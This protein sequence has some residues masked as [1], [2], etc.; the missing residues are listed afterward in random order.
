MCSST[1]SLAL[2]QVL[3]IR[4]RDCCKSLDV[5]VHTFRLLSTV[6]VISRPLC[7]QNIDLTVRHLLLIRFGTFHSSWL[8]WAEIKCMVHVA[9]PKQPIYQFKPVRKSRQQVLIAYCPNLY[10]VPRCFGY[11][12]YG[13]LFNIY[14]HVIGKNNVIGVN[15]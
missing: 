4:N 9:L 7:T 6:S 3:G 8:I 13:T 10:I 1:F 12:L 14:R 15:R 2:E 5:F 11:G